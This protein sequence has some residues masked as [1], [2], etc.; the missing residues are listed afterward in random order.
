MLE[1]RTEKRYRLTEP[2]EGAVRVFRDVIVR[3]SGDDEWIVTSREG[4]IAGETLVLETDVAGYEDE[5]GEPRNRLA[6]C[7]IESRPVIV[8]GDMQHRIRLHPGS[9]P[10]VLFEPQIRRG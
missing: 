10:P 9:F 2:T 4:A 3:M 5:D 8:D 7:V 6:V 1:R